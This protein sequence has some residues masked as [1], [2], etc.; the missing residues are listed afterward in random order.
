MTAT[1]R[2]SGRTRTGV[3]D[4][5]AASDP[6]Y[7]RLT[8]ALRTVCAIV[9]TLVVL[10][11]LHTVVFHLV[12]GAMAAMVATFGVR[13]KT[14]P[15]QAVTLVIGLITACVSMSLGAVLASH[16]IPS[17]LVFLALIFCAVYARRFG[18]RGYTIGLFGFQFYFVSL[19]VHASP[20]SLPQ[21]WLALAVAFAS[22]AVSRF[23]LFR[24]STVG[25]LG[26][27]RNA[28]RAR[29][30]QLVATQVEMFDATPDE[31]EKVLA[32]L[33]R[34]TAR[35][36]EAALMIQGRLDDEPDSVARADVLQRRIADAEIAAERL[37]V[38]LL[39]ARSAERADTLTMHL[40]GAPVPRQPAT[41]AL[42]ADTTA[43][44]RRDLAALHL[45]ISRLGPEHRGT[46]HVRLR[47][48]LLG[49]REEENLPAGPP[50]VQDVFRGVGEA[51]RAVL[52]L[53]LALDGP[54]DE[55][56][57]TAETA[58]SRE[59]F[60]AEAV[61]A[62]SAES[63]EEDETGLRRRSTRAAFQ[64]C[65]GSV[66]AMAGGEFLSAQRWYWAV[67]T[68]WV[69]FLN[70]SSTGE[71][72][73]KGYRRLI[74][75]VCGVVAGVAL[76]GLVGNHT[77]TAFGLVLLCIF[78][79]FFTAPLSYAL[80]SFFVTSMLGLLYT[81][82]HT[83]SVA[84]LVLRIEE[85][86]LGAACGMFAAL[87]VLPVRTGRRTDQQLRTVLLRL[88]E[89][90]SAAVAQLSGGAPAD[91]LDMARDLDTALDD[92]RRSTQPLT[93]P[94]T[95]LRE[96]RQSARYLVALLESGAYHARSLAA[97]AELVPYSK[98]VAADPRLARA[99]DRLAHNIAVLAA[100]VADE[101]ADGEVESGASIASMLEET[102]SEA[103]RTGSVTFRVL[104]HLQRL[105]EGVIGL[106]RPLGVPVSGPEE[107]TTRTAAA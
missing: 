12:A 39:N 51:T 64:V 75:T 97:T 86:A 76:A 61:S 3:F 68:C 107:R 41:G 98:R 18:D 60:E 69:V 74:G 83:Y 25:T 23:V 66:L 84:V 5:F 42:G 77:W 54:G 96:R 100:H 36:H 38:L 45:L 53:R 79:M 47:N 28:F 6:G 80:M 11:A 30:A 101:R 32:D 20:S 44:L 71:I 65:A 103:L 67:L 106:A 46:A 27:L 33:R 10:Y 89:V 34:D 92:L 104:R 9:L 87:I 17:D 99:G 70:T 102:D 91:L 43:L 29:L 78:G 1:P 4:R 59:E 52:G 40:P 93:H 56:D 14:R 73:V 49:Y 13:E 62:G 16:R 95:P 24:Q 31:L 58:R 19:F 72:L 105:D 8:S 90:A 85:T 82:L 55:S 26:R 21:I 63:G 81:L 22:S 35:L 7:I 94:F 2:S 57:D 48:R 15:K 88:G 37:G 50:A